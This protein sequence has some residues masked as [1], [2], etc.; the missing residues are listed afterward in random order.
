MPDLFTK[1]SSGK[2][3]DAVLERLLNVRGFVFDMDGTLVLGDER[4][5]GLKPLPGA[6]ELTRWLSSRGVPYVVFTNGTARTPQ[7]YARTL[8]E[9]GFLITDEN[10]MTPASCAADLFVSRGYKRVMAFGGAGVTQ[11]LVEAGIEIVA[12]TGKARVDAV[13]AGWH[14][15]FTMDALESACH[16]MWNGASM[17]SASQ[18]RFFAT[19]EGKALAPRA[20]FRQ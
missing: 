15:E 8:R 5:H 9:A 17:F 10:M 7:D 3:P 12:P 19:A 11:P 16:A 13:L 1:S 18:T 6:L 2:I 20:P 14:R 4:N